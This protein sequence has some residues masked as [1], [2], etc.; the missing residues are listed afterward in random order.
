MK[1]K[2]E[3]DYDDFHDQ[4]AH[5]RA[6]SATDAFLALHSIEELLRNVYKYET[7]NGD[8]VPRGALGVVDKLRDEFYTILRKYNVNLEDLE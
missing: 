7:L 2:L 4:L 3:F 5:R 1:A 8:K 6:V